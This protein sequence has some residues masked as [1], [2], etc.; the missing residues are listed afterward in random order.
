MTPAWTILSDDLTGLQAIAG[1]FA[2]LGFRVGTG[3]SRVPSRKA[4][5]SFE[6]YGFDTA[7]RALQP[8][9]AEAWVAEA[10]RQIIAAGADRIFKHNDSI[11]Q[12]HVGAEL[13]AINATV[14]RR[15]MSR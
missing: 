6:I 5:E 9:E 12:G 13:R 7:T 1:E 10:A 3:M 11:L 2:R 15:R 8:G 4:L 14:P